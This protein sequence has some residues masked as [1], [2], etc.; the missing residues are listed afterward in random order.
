[1]KYQ[2]WF[3]ESTS[4]KDEFYYDVAI[5]EISEDEPETDEDLLQYFE[6]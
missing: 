3:S 4:I 6:N 1:M 2:K 5:E